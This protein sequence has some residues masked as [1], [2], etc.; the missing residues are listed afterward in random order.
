MEPVATELEPHNWIT[1]LY[2][3]QIKENEEL[4]TFNVALQKAF[5]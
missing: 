4:A 1:V 5:S 2:N 3:L